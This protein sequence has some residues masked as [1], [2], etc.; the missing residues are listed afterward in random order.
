MREY[1]TKGYHLLKIMYEQAYGSKW[2][3]YGIDFPYFVIDYY[4]LDIHT[5][6]WEV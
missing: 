6:N 1:L 4:Y 5:Y 3:I 2:F